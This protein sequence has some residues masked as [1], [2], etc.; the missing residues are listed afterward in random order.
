MA[1]PQSLARRGEGSAWLA[2]EPGLAEAVAAWDRDLTPLR[3]RFTDEAV[4]LAR[5]GP[6]APARALRHATAMGVHRAVRFG[7]RLPGDVWALTPIR[8][9]QGWMQESAIEAFVDQ[10]ALGGAP[11]A[12]VARLIREAGSLFPSALVA[13]IDRRSIQPPPLRMQVV[14]DILRRAFDADIAFDPRSLTSVPVSEL[15]FAVLPDHR[16]AAVRVRRPG[17]ARGVRDDTRLTASVVAPLQ[18]ALP[19]VSGMHPLGFVQLTIRLGLESTDMRFEALNAI[20]LGLV[21]EELGVTGLQV[22]RPMP[23]FVSRRAVVSEYLPGRPLAEGGAVADPTAALAALTTLTLE[24]ALIHG[25][26]WA[27]PAPEHLLVRDDGTLA[28]VG[29]GTVGHLPPDLKIAGIRFLRSFLSGDAEGQA[30]AMRVAGAVP[31]DADLDAL[32]ADLAAADALQVS[33]ILAGGE[34]GLLDGLNQAVRLLLFHQLRPP[35]EVVLLLRTVFALGALAE[36]LAPGGGGLATA[37][38]PL[39]MRLPDLL[40]EAERPDA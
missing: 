35:L 31:P 21:A 29:T 26:F 23:R 25:V 38:M 19:Q 33:A 39:M 17:V 2:A 37:L 28:I 3:H 20:E 30:D 24:S 22:A 13:E 15:H 4:A 7:T 27:D 16:Q 18:R 6:V 12:E 10:L 36:R 9:P 40:A 34:R 32:I 5:P 11:T 14:D 8:D 1:E